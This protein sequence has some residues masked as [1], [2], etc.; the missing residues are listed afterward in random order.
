ME[1][2]KISI[3]FCLILIFSLLVSTS[4][5]NAASENLNYK[6]ITIY[7]GQTKTLKIKNTTKKVIW[8]SKNKSIA[9]VNSKGVVTAKKV[10]TTTIIAKVN[11]K[12]FKCKVTI[13]KE[14]LNKA[15]TTICKNQ[16]TTLKVNN[17]IKKVAWSTNNKSIATVNSKGVVTGKKAG[18]ATITAKVNGKTLKCKV[19]ITEHSYKTISIKKATCTTNGYKKLECK[20]CGYDYKSILKA[21]GHKYTSMV[22]VKPTCTKAGYEKTTC[23]NCNNIVTVN[24]KK[25]GHDYSSEFIVDKEATCKKTGT[26][27]RHCTRCEFITDKTVIP[28]TEH[29]Y[30]SGWRIIKQAT[31]TTDG[32]KSKTCKVCDLSLIQDITKLGHNYS[33]I[34]TIDKEATCETSGSKSK[35]CTRSGCTTKSSVTTIAPTGHSY[36]E[37]KVTKE[38]TEETTGTKIKTCIICSNVITEVIAQL[39]KKEAFAVYSED[40]GSLAF[41]KRISV[42]KK[43]SKFEGKTVSNVYTGIEVTN[44]NSDTLI[45]DECVLPPW[46]NNLV[47]VNEDI[48][49]VQFVDKIS[50]I[51]TAHW[52][53]SF[54]E[55]E[56]IDL[57][58]LD[59]S[60]L[61]NMD[62]MFAGCAKLETIKL[63]N[64]FDTSR[65]E[66][67]AGLFDLCNVLTIDCSKWNVS[68]VE[69]KPE[70][71]IDADYYRDF[72]SR[73]NNNNIIPPNWK[74]N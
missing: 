7:V 24:L 35:H 50:P 43:G 31:C 27:S 13:P 71:Y 63:P 41:Y 3:I 21:T 10:G 6:N 29:S 19:T 30:S 64:N 34:F 47:K 46:I 73:G 15:S 33:N 55:V 40:D 56:Y 9:T 38:P 53:Y 12:T 68:N 54:A 4:T 16:T 37:W 20:K 61:K 8:S 14:K 57:T 28:L 44:Y 36:G 25:L 22:V 51:S 72:W 32:A 48:K 2:R 23:E 58:N 74:W 67:M 66:S 18:T 17:N 26:K 42:P 60:N 5:V 62:C 70:Y 52:F 39:P 69:L 45:L 1:K 11:G 49:T 59:M 65:V